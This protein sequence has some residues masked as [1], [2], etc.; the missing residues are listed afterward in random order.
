M[1]FQNTVSILPGRT[2]SW[3]ERLQTVLLSIVTQVREIAV[4]DIGDFESVDIIEVLVA[5]GDVI[6]AE[7]PLVTLESDKATMDVPAPFGGT[8]SELKVQ[9]GDKVAQG[10][11][12]CTIETVDDRGLRTSRHPRPDRTS[13]TTAGGRPGDDRRDAACGTPGTATTPDAAAPR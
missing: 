5:P 2:R 6:R 11:V 8:I 12:L 4:P 9:T 10:S 1:Q 3:H 7:D 13:L